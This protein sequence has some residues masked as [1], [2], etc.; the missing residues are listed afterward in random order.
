[1]VEHKRTEKPATTG[2]SGSTRGG[3]PEQHSKSARGIK[4][5]EESDTSERSSGSHGGTSKQGRHQS[6]V[7]KRNG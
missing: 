2:H 5:S 1:M 4:S 7:D 6:G 3:T